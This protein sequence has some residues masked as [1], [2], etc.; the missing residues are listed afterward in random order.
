MKTST[1]AS[2]LVACAL[3]TGALARPAWSRPSAVRS[4]TA[5]G[6][7]TREPTRAAVKM[8]LKIPASPHGVYV[9]QTVPVTIR[10]YFLGGTGVTLNGQPH[11]TADSL[12]LSD[13]PAQPRQASVQIHGLPYTALTWEGKVT[14]V[15]AGPVKTEVELPVTLTYREAPRLRPP[16]SDDDAGGGSGQSDDPFSSF[17][18]QSPFA[19]DPF[20]SR[21]FQG[22]DPFRGMFDDLAG[23]ARQREVTLR[24]AG[25]ALD[26]VEPPAPRPTDFT[27]AVGSFDVS[28]ALSD[29]TFRVGEP[30]HLKVTVRGQGSFARLAIA[31]LPATNDL[32]TYGVTSEFT[33][34]PTPLGGEKVFT[35]T[36]TPR[37]AGDLT[38]PSVALTYFD[39]RARRYV[40]RRT[41]PLPITVAPPDGNS[42][43]AGSANDNAAAAA[44]PGEAPPPPAAA[45]VDDRPASLIPAFET[46]SFWM[47]VG[48]I[49]AATLAAA[50]LG[51]TR[52]RG[53]M[54]RRR[55]ERRIRR[56]I[57]RQRR[58]IDEAAARGDTATLFAAGRKALQL[59]LGAKWGVP[60]EAIAAAD[61]ATRLGEDGARI[62][63]VFEQA[64]QASY[65][66][67]R[68]ADSATPDLHGWQHLILDE[69]HPLEARA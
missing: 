27:G 68:R 58:Q 48:A 8:D 45:L 62:R 49:A 12:L 16:V 11:L 33:A 29:G 59:R 18:R 35:Q 67:T 42:I 52:R 37:R 43:T 28:A 2:I 7:S 13:L 65:A 23:A 4:S 36:L 19:N 50:I 25:S 54:G 14:A 57:A 5:D 44:A 41:A 69:L 46:V 53:A 30:T 64:D 24:D 47:L 32:N 1:T 39:P 61:V 26:V 15:K 40:T 6:A 10:A 55:S 38:V 60:A 20:F 51:W 9:G 66:G 17:L 31:G 3:L 22:G 21:M 56:E 34:G 63:D